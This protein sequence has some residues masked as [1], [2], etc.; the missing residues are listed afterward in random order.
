MVVLRAIALALGTLV[1]RSAPLLVIALVLG[2]WTGWFD[3]HPWVLVALLGWC[4]L[5]LLEIW[6]EC[7]R[8]KA[9]RNIPKTP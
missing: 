3:S 8:W 9:K 4:A 1:V 2:F 7:R 5:L 6:L